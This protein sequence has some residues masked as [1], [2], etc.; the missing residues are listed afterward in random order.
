MLRARSIS[1]LEAEWF[2]FEPESGQVKAAD[3]VGT[4]DWDDGNTINNDGCKTPRL[5]GETS[6]N[7]VTC[8]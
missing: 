7:V 4:K 1:I 8:I 3:R 6:N 2:T 5:D